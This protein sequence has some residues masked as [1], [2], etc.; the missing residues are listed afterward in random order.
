MTDTAVAPGLILSRWAFH[1]ALLLWTHAMLAVALTVTE[2]SR[3]NLTSLHYWRRG[4]S[5]VVLIRVAAAWVP[6]LISAVYSVRVVTYLRLRFWSF[7]AVLLIGAA[8]QE[9][10]FLG[11]IQFDQ[12][13]PETF[14]KMVGLC[15]LYIW[16]AEFIM[17][18]DD[19]EWPRGLG[20]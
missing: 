19:V 3:V 4:A 12:G 14:W 11:V 5:T 7:F 9:L 17:H 16:A 20:P 18:V 2:L 13:T 10:Y 1:R 6:Y 15:N 8:A